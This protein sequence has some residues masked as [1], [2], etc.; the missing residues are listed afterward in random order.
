MCVANF[1]LKNLKYFN[2]S[3]AKNFEVTLGIAHRA[4]PK[5]KRASILP[6]RILATQPMDLL[7]SIPKHSHF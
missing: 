5:V 1:S 4:I 2:K 7:C 6:K 3:F